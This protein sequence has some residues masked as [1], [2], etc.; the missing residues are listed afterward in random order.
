VYSGA[1][2]ARLDGRESL[3]REDTTLD[4]LLK[5]SRVGEK[6]FKGHSGMF[7]VFI[8]LIE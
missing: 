7:P 4:V 2:L 5:G 1:L 8:F 3:S 6:S